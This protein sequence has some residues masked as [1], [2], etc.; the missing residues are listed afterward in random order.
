MSNKKELKLKDNQVKLP[1]SGLIAEVTEIK[2]KDIMNMRRVM[3]DSDLHED[4]MMYAL[5]AMSVK[6]DGKKLVLEDIPEMDGYDFIAILNLVQSKGGGF[7]LPQN[8]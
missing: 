7:T 1:T 8:R 5:I 2:A 4:Q 3:G 6:V